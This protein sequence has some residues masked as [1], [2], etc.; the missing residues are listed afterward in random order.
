MIL[1][2]LW[3]ERTNLKSTKRKPSSIK[4]Q[5]ER[6]ECP[7]KNFVLKRHTIVGFANTLVRNY[8][9]NSIVCM[10]ACLPKGLSIV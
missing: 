7:A 8:Q 10:S 9:G 2:I 4:P 5:Y 6:T 1:L 3:C